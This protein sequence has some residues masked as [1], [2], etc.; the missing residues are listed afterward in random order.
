[1]KFE[2]HKRVQTLFAICDSI[3]FVFF[4]F[5][6]EAVTKKFFFK[7]FV[8]SECLDQ[9]VLLKHF[10]PVSASCTMGSYKFL[11]WGGL[12]NPFNPNIKIQIL[13]CYPYKFSVEVVGRICWSIN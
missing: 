1:M 13:I 5:N 11:T 3:N 12:F 2:E 8:L 4:F 6:L 10:K 7:K 9:Y